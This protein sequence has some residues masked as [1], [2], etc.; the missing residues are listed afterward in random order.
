MLQLP[1]IRA[2]FLTAGQSQPW[3]CPNDIPGEETLGKRKAQPAQDWREEMALAKHL[4]NGVDAPHGHFAL[5]LDTAHA[6]GEHV[7][8]QGTWEGASPLASDPKNAHT[9]QI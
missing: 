6:Q 8:E 5:C 7:H 3:M 1:D 2:C 4:S 9:D